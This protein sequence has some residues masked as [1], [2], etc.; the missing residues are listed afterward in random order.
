MSLLCLKPCTCFFPALCQHKATD[1]NGL[2]YFYSNQRQEP[3]HVFGLFFQ[4]SP[5]LTA[6][7]TLHNS[8][9]SPV[10][11]PLQ[12]QLTG[13]WL[14]WG[15][16]P[17]KGK[18]GRSYLSL[19]LQVSSCCSHMGQRVDPFLYEQRMWRQSRN[20]HAGIWIAWN[21]QQQITS[22]PPLQLDESTRWKIT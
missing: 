7:F 20:L 22:S 9:I 1:F 14:R 10:S 19:M 18:N 11:K 21:E 2:S 5:C 12:L 3:D 8:S 16:V 15:F 13:I 6:L 4:P 17:S